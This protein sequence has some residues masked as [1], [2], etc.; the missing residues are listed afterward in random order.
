MCKYSRAV[1]CLVAVLCSRDTVEMLSSPETGARPSQ[2]LL[3][4]TFNWGTDAARDAAPTRWAFLHVGETASSN[5]NGPPLF[6]FT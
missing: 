5:V 1:S 4:C 3:T 6:Y 2:S